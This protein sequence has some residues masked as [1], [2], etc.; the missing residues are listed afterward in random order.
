MAEVRA[1]PKDHPRETALA[2]AQ[3]YEKGKR[4]QDMGKA[5]D[6]AEKLP[7]SNDDKETVLFMRGAMY[8]RMKRYDAAEAEF[9]KV[10]E[11]NPDNAGALNYLGYMLADRNM[12]LE[13]ATRLLRRLWN[14]SRTTAPTWTAWDGST[15]G[16]AG[17]SDAEGLLVRA[18]DRIGGQDPTVHDHLGD[19]YFK[20][21]KT[22][23]AITQWQAS[24]KEF[25]VGAPTDIDPD[26]MAK[27]SKKLE[28]ARI[29][30]AQEMKKQQ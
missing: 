23:E 9:R 1:L 30:L 3:M 17:W 24:L 22:R 16:R 19:V 18:L 28:G 14:W 6:E 27:V 26:E 11:L 25:Q 4:W 7:E 13:E 29:R 5:L 20:L 21:G 15:T 10:M 12:K 8:E 2:L